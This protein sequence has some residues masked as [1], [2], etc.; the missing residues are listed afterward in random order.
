MTFIWKVMIV[1][2]IRQSIPEISL[3]IELSGSYSDRLGSFNGLG[4]LRF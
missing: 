4:S 3:L 2:P 1:L